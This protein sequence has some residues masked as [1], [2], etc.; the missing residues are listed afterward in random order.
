[1]GVSALEGLEFVRTTIRSLHKLDNLDLLGERV[2][3]VLFES[4]HTD[5]W[6]LLTKGADANSYIIHAAVAAGRALREL[7]NSEVLVSDGLL[8]EVIKMQR[9]LYT[10]DIR[11][12][13][14]F[15]EHDDDIVGEEHVKGE[16]LIVPLMVPDRTGAIGL[17]ALYDVEFTADPPYYLSLYKA[18]GSEIASVID[19]LQTIRDLKRAV[20]TDPLTGLPNRR[21]LVNIIERET[22]QCRRYNRPISFVL[23]DVDRFKSI[24]D[25]DG[26]LHGDAVLIR[27]GNILRK[28]V[29]K[30]D[31]VMRFSGDE[32]LI[33]MPDTS[34]SQQAEVVG[35][36]LACFER[37]KL[38][39]SV[40]YS[41]S[42]GVYSGPPRSLQIMF[43][44]AD[45]EM[46][47]QK[48][49][50]YKH[51]PTARSTA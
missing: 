40:E 43:N 21:A 14:R 16:A 1:M 11:N 7:Y 31:Y 9:T 51:I 41:L 15:N 4:H 13:I 10:L 36:V 42:L 47:K 22:E 37:E 46:Y 20:L 19:R 25:T 8:K 17:L 24:N 5:T 6:I 48:A 45:K 27:I 50:R 34:H 44:I 2:S 38:L 32:F 26:H 35:R 12:D 29:R 3:S 39:A 28:S 33:L 30:L 23:I 18:L 49:E